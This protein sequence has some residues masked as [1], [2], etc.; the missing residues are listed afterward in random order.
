MLVRVDYLFGIKGSKSIN[1]HNIIAKNPE[2]N[3]LAGYILLK[4]TYSIRDSSRQGSKI[5]YRVWLTFR[6]KYIRRIRKQNKGKLPCAYC[7][8]TSLN[9][10]HGS[11]H[12]RM[13]G[14]ATI[15]HI[16][17]L[18]KGGKKFD[19]SNLIVAC[20]ACNGAKADILPENFVSKTQRQSKNVA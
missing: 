17:P 6:N 16:L 18:S 10:N 13:S 7:D 1:K 9:P 3:S 19:E 15:D 8:K 2:P 12:A 20:S 4:Q 14:K 11:A 5:H